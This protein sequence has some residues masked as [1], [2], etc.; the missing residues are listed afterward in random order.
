MEKLYENGI[1]YFDMNLISENR[2]CIELS[3]RSFYGKYDFLYDNFNLERLYSEL[4]NF[5]INDSEIIYNFFDTDSDSYIVFTKEKLGHLSV[6][7]QLGSKFSG[8]YLCFLF[9]ADQTLINIFMER[10][11]CFLQI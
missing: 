5:Q 11:A 2:I 7:G 10:I 9:N 4:N 6:S 1:D 8:T 3:L